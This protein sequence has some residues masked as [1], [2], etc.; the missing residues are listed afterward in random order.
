MRLSY[1]EAGTGGP[2]IVLV[3]GW[4]F[5]DRSHLAPQFEHLASSRRVLAPDLPGHGAS[6]LPPAG[7]GFAD[8]ATAI[9]GALD[10][11][12]VER[13]VLCGHSFGGR[14][15]VEVAAAY[16]S[17]VAGAALLD[18]VILFPEPLRLQ[19]QGLAAQL[20]SEAWLPALEAYFTR[21][22]SPDDPPDLR[23]R[24]K[25]Q[26]AEVP[27]EVAPRV[28]RDGMATDGSEA[29]SRVRCPLLVVR[30]A[31]HP[32]DLQRLREL[33]PEAWVGCVVGTGHWLTLTVPDQVN[34][35]LDRFLEVKVGTT[36]RV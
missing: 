14:L 12:G 34:A 23:A 16:P 7:F 29:L 33:Q 25:R 26:L 22:L 8:C 18:P 1:A 28:M 24:V 6:E 17:R 36:A 5:G 10:E 27:R 31:E 30:R 13:A 21:L 35:M 15:A 2:A 19:A 11:A 20:E 3:H 9:V 4:A 32:M